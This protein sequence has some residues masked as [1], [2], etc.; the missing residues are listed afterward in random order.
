MRTHRNLRLAAIVVFSC[1][2]EQQRCWVRYTLRTGEEGHSV[3][4]SLQQRASIRSA[5]RRDP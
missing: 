4:G 2:R 3:S 5:A 1:G